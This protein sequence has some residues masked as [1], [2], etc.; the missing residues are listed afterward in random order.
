MTVGT[1]VPIMNALRPG[2]GSVC[3]AAESSTVPW[4][5]FEV[6]MTG[7]CP[8]TTMFSSSAPTSRVRSSVMNC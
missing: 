5:A 6:S 7:D 3:R 4:E 1:V 8:V 2:A